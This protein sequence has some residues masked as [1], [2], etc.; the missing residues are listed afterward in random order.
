M[1]LHAIV[2]GVVLYS[3]AQTRSVFRFQIKDEAPK[4]IKREMFWSIGMRSLMLSRLRSTRSG[5]DSA[6][7]GPAGLL[8][9]VNVLVYVHSQKYRLLPAISILVVSPLGDSFP[10]LSD[11]PMVFHSSRAQHR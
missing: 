7:L 6:D 9:F 8:G 2:S 3:A 4:Q 11:T 5:L 10:K 1:A